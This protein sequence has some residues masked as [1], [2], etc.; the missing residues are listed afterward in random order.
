MAVEQNNEFLNSTEEDA[1]D[2]YD[3]WAILAARLDDLPD[4]ARR[5]F[6]RLCAKID[7]FDPHKDDE[8][9]LT[10]H[11]ETPVIRTKK[12]KVLGAKSPHDYAH[13][14]DWVVAWQKTEGVSLD[15]SFWDYVEVHDLQHDQYETI[16]SA[17]HK[18]RRARL[19]SMDQHRPH[20]KSG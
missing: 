2:A 6:E 20:F 16:K 9:A 7:E 18:V 15:Q 8:L 13:V 4:G 5:Y 14:F 10:N 11:L 12:R 1:K 3:A 19:A 17:Y